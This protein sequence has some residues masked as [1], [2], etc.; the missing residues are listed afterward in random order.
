[1]P[2]ADHIL[3]PSSAPTELCR[4]YLASGLH[5]E[6][7]T[8]HYEYVAD[9]RPAA[10]A[11]LRLCP[12]AHYLFYDASCGDGRDAPWSSGWFVDSAF[13]NS[14]AWSP[15]STAA[16]IGAEGAD[17]P[18]VSGRRP[19]RQ[20]DPCRRRHQHPHGRRGVALEQHICRVDIRPYF[21]LG[22]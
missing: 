7:L 3:S 4:D 21:Y 22:D 8:A 9:T 13:P 6:D 16:P 11:D 18:P 12:R 14:L 2:P 10:E 20:W 1:M 15:Q 5:D 17:C 19:R